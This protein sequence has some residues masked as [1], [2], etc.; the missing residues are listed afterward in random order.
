MFGLLRKSFLARILATSML[1]IFLVGL[2]LIVCSYVIQGQVLESQVHS[3]ATKIMS[4]TSQNLNSE[5]I[6]EAASD[7]NENSSVHKKLRSYFDTVSANNPQVS[8]AYI[9]GTELEGGNKTSII[10]MPT[11]VLETFKEA[12]LNIGDLYEQP[13]VISDSVRKMLSTGEVIY[14]DVYTDDYGTWM[15]VLKPFKNEQG[16]ITAY[17]G[18]DIDASIVAKGKKD[19]LLYSSLALL[20]ILAILLTVQFYLVRKSILPLRE[21]GEGIEKFSQGSFEISLKEGDDEIGRLNKKFNEMVV[22]MHQ[23]IQAIKEAYERNAD[24]SGKLSEAVKEGSDHYSFVVSELQQISEQMKNQETATIDS[25]SSI[26]EI[27]SGISAIA[28]YSAD[29]SSKAE[30][31][32]TRA[33]KGNKAV[34]DIISQ[35][36][37]AEQS[38][39]NSSQALQQL[40][41]K[42]TEISGIVN[43][44][45]EIAEQT[46]L[47]ALNA[48]IEAARAGEHGKGFAVVADEVRKLAEQSRI[49]A[50]QIKG[51][52]S[53][54]QNEVDKAVSSISVGVETVSTSVNSSGELTQIFAHIMD[55]IHKV[56]SQVQEISA[57]TQQVAAESEEV[58]SV[59]EQLS[60]IAKH[61]TE[62]SAGI[63]QMTE[64]Q[65]GNME[66]IADDAEEM[67]KLFQKL[68]QSISMFK[69]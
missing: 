63:S 21:L 1:N 52:I 36:N 16:K 32:E 4:G 22:A 55:D 2:T 51:L 54:I 44:I 37:S 35:M 29:V 19:L 56:S 61:N 23:I 7:S 15:S 25:S 12:D 42:S 10:S 39:G 28:D 14:T 17:Y 57:S 66:L 64:A 65:K 26:N 67:N 8:Q 49:S 50:E 13:K 5:E 31:L 58:A 34:K 46:N 6:M 20:I 18:I 40:D 62:T 24:Y 69:I 27:V 38:V 43:L 41:E 45:S 11:A 3:Q 59:I 33:Q 47:L 68:Q 60:G 48:A 30:E 9:F 53:I